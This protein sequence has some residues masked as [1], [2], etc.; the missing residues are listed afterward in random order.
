MTYR[1]MFT[2]YLLLR[3]RFLRR[4]KKTLS[5]DD[6]GFNYKFIS[7][8]KCQIPQWDLNHIM[9]KVAGTVCEDGGPRMEQAVRWSRVSSH[10]KD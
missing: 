2:Q 3:P 8:K 7:H 4:Q 1:K 6:W 9:S 5:S 10:S